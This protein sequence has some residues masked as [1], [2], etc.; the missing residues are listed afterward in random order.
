MERAKGNQTPESPLSKLPELLRPGRKIKSPLEGGHL[1]FQ[2]ISGVRS[3]PAI[4]QRRSL[5]TP[6]PP[7]PTGMW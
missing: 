2:K 5:R 1:W 6:L 7:V 4:P 3:V